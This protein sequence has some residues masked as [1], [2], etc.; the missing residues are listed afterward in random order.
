M[1]IKHIAETEIISVEAYF[2]RKWKYTCKELTT[3]QIDTNFEIISLA[4]TLRTRKWL[5]IGLY[6]PP[7]QKEEYLL[8]NTGVALNI[9]LSKYKHILLRDF[10][11]AT[12]NKYLADFM[13]LFNLKV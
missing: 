4:I 6:K 13:T 5:V 8:K 9:Y 11:L 2:L 7:N 10:N 3:K 1:D 12:S